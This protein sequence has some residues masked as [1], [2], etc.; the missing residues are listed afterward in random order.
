[1]DAYLSTFPIQLALEHRKNINIKA[2]ASN[3][4]QASVVKTSIDDFQIKLQMREEKLLYKLRENEHLIE[5]SHMMDRDE[6]SM[7]L[8]LISLLSSYPS[9]FA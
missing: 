4:E 6:I 5:S 3:L 9:L 8:S 7:V 2:I 1:M